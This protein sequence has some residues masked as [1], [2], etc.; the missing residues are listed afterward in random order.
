MKPGGNYRDKLKKS[1]IMRVT[2]KVFTRQKAQMD[3]K[4]E[5][6]IKRKQL[7]NAE[8]KRNVLNRLLE[9]FSDLASLISEG[10]LDKS[11]RPS[12]LRRQ[13]STNVI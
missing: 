2:V 10:E 3:S 4:T 11:C 1:R 6:R 8:F 13:L 7:V 5:K 12:F 9:M